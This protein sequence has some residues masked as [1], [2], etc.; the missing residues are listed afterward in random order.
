M[1]KQCLHWHRCLC[2][3]GPVPSTGL[4][5]QNE[6]LR[7]W[8]SLKM[9]KI[10]EPN[11]DCR[12][13]ASHSQQTPAVD[14]VLLNLGVGRPCLIRLAAPM[15]IEE[16]TVSS[17]LD[18][19]ISFSS[20]GIY[21]LSAPSWSEHYAIGQSTCLATPSICNSQIQPNLRLANRAPPW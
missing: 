15:S 6:P 14:A 17:S 12:P 10:Q 20:S 19:L 16:T 18:Y 11:S 4:P 1:L 5:F 9:P 8:G 7:T 13:G 2:W 3:N 21:P